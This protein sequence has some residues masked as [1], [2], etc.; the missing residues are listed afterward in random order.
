MKYLESKSLPY[1]DKIKVF[2]FINNKLEELKNNPYYYGNNNNGNTEIN[3]FKEFKNYISTKI[4]KLATISIEE[5][6]KLILT[7][8]NKEQISII[9][10]LDIVPEIQLQ[11]LHFFTKEIINNYNNENGNSNGEGISEEIK[12]IFLLYFKLLIKMDKC[13]YL[14]SALKENVYFYPL[15][16]CLNL[17]LKNGLNEVSIFIY[18]ILGKYNEALSISIKEID[19]FYIKAKNIIINKDDFE[20]DID[21]RANL[22]DVKEDL[23]YK[24]QRNI[25]V[26]LKICQK[27]SGKDLKSSFGN[28]YIQLWYNLFIKL[29]EIYEDIKSSKENK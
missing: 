1:E 16:K 21:T 6:E 25:N 18:E 24:L 23:F 4:E 11:Y 13:N 17:T 12:D 7:W 3:Y 28:I 9:N 22:K 20:L 27:V 26:G 5:L 10:K 2:N 19:K 29:F 8:F 15:D 14:I